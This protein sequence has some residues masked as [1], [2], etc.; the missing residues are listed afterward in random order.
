M[1]ISNMNW[2]QVEAYLKSEDRCI[3][4]LGCTEQHA[5]LSLSTDSILAERMAMDAAAAENIIV[6]PV[7]SYTPSPSFAAF[8]GTVSIRLSTFLSL[9]TDIVIRLYETGFR[10]ILFVNGH[11]GNTPAKVQCQELLGDMPGLSIKFHS[12]WD[13]PE[14]VAAAKTIRPDPSHANWFENFP[15]TRLEGISAPT[16]SKPM[17]DTALVDAASPLTAKEML[18]DGSYGGAYQA[19]E[20]AMK[21]LW[22]TGVR[23]TRE[24]LSA[25][26]PT[27][28]S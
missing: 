9:I 17:I 27:S 14:T 10:R 11:G 24:Q 20:T 6:F 5:F 23:E 26:W 19:D 8:P 13:A 25:V 7:V 16:E 1:H 18:Q 2:H 21:T 4:P 28:I 3:V 22:E 12:W 15:W